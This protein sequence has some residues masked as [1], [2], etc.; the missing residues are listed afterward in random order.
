MNLRKLEEFL[1]ASI[2]QSCDHAGATQDDSQG[3]ISIYC[4]KC[5]LA[6]SIHPEQAALYERVA[7]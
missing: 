5:G 2:A 1:A 7:S 6:T 3:Y 4:P